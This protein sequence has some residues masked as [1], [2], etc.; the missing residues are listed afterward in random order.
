MPTGRGR[1]LGAALRAAFRAS[2]WA[3]GREAKGWHARLSAMTNTAKGQHALIDAGLVPGEHARN[4][5]RWLAEDRAMSPANQEKLAQAYR[6]Y[7]LPREI[8]TATAKISGEIRTE[9]NTFRDRGGSEAPLQ[10]SHRGQDSTTAHDERWDRVEDKWLAGVD[11][12]E[13]EDVYYDEVI[14]DDLDMSEWE[15]TGSGY[16]VVIS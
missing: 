12:D 10:I 3:T 7:R 6:E 11:A 13:L 14:S 5:R 1:T 8:R 9:G 4:W 15:T 2:G 16:S